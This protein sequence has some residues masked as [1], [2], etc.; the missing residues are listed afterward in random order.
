MKNNWIESIQK[1]YNLFTSDLNLAEIERLI[2][3]DTREMVVYYTREIPREKSTGT[4][5][6]KALTFVKN[7]VITFLLKLTPARRLLYIISLILFGVFIF[8]SHLAA[9]IYSFLIVN[10]LLALELADKLITKDELALARDIQ[11]SLLPNHIVPVSGFD[12]VAFSDAAKSVGGDYYDFIP[13]GDGSTLVVIGDISGHGMSAALYMVKVQTM[14]RMFAANTADP[15]QL[16]VMLN[17]HL[18]DDFKR[19]YFLTISLLRLFP[20]GEYQLCRAGHTPL[21][22]YDCLGNLCSWI[23]PR[24]LAIG[25]VPSKSANGKRASV[26]YRNLDFE[27]TLEVKKGS[28]N[29]GDTLFLFTD[30]VVETFNRDDEEFGQD[31]LVHLFGRFHDAQPRQ[32]REILLKELAIFRHGADLRDDTTF[33]IMKHTQ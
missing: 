17:D 19:N 25:M 21:L 28:I 27:R 13:L 31:R 33:V 26:T 29:R 30:G 11:L 6:K 12:Y 7:V 10:F 18:Y 4:G 24:G 15:R 3:I 1:F 14:L 9:V 22:Y 20:T 2:K 8:Q 16:S 5:W 23:A 32:L